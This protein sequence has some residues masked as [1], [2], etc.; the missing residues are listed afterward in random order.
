MIIRPDAVV[1]PSGIQIGIEV[2]LS[3]G[4]IEDIRPWSSEVR[5]E[6]GLIL[7]PKFVNSHSHL[8]YFDMRQS[9]SPGSYWPWIAELT[10]R[11][12]ERDPN[13]VK[14][15]ID[16]AARENLATG[17]WA[18]GEWSDWDGSDR[19]MTDNGL[20]GAIF[21]EVIT[22]H[23][24]DSPAEKLRVVGERARAATMPTYVTPHAPYTVAPQVIRELA[25]T[26]EPLSIHAAETDEENAFYLRGDGP[27]SELYN[28]AGIAIAPPGMT[29]ISYLDSLG[30][31][32]ARTQLVHLCAAT[33]EDIGLIA[34]RKCTVAHCPRSNLALGCPTPQIGRMIDHGIRV[35]LGLD[36]AASSGNIDMFAEM[37]CAMSLSYSSSRPLVA[38]EV[39]EMAITTDVV[40]G[41][42]ANKIEIGASPSMMLVES[43]PTFD[44]LLSCSPKDVRQL[45]L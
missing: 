10:K 42:S 3:S 45:S 14:G 33:E 2:C 11:K 16:V 26:G 43:L 17:V 35:G 18:I 32:H 27:I 5:N 15:W 23:E 19:A 44:A 6:V 20:A 41:L 24:W 4:A 30:A 22:I 7:S 38:H 21:Q 34:E 8:E 9:L 39:W 29:S 12:Q 13:R 25:Q 1:T 28:H 36:S 37:R 40:P 31:L